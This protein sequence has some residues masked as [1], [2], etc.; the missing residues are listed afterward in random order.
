MTDKP[1]NWQQ[2][3]AKIERGESGDKIGG[4]DPAAAPI[5]KTIGALDRLSVA[6]FRR[7]TRT[8]S[9]HRLVQAAARDSLGSDGATWAASAVQACEAAYPGGDFKH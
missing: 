6:E 8:F 1:E 5:E 3:R 2:V 9:V 7:E 4:F